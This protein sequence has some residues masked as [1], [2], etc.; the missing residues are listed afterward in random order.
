MFSR[1]FMIALCAVSILS[2][3]CQKS[4]SGSSSS[5][6]GSA[7]APAVTDKQ[8]LE[9]TDEADDAKEGELSK[10]VEAVQSSGKMKFK[11][12]NHRLSMSN[13]SK[14]IIHSVECRERNPET[15]ALE[16]VSD[17]SEGLPI[18]RKYLPA[19]GI[20][21]VAIYLKDSNKKMVEV[22]REDELGDDQIAQKS[23]SYIQG[24]QSPM[25]LAIRTEVTAKHILIENRD[26]FD[27]TLKGQTEGCRMVKEIFIERTAA[28]KYTLTEM[29][30]C[31]VEATGKRI[32]SVEREVK[33]ENI[34]EPSSK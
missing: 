21:G 24:L 11:L 25:D 2:S 12:W 19:C 20:K 32:I 1:S 4:E 5:E 9:I 34:F 31:D 33:F 22:I 17:F 10:A 13:N 28:R 15:G 16:A 27:V 14:R 8:S 7:P 26:T 3:A 23:S 18:S 6:V 30:F 29:L